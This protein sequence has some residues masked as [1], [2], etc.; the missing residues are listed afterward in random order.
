MMREGAREARYVR[1]A[2]PRLSSV[3]KRESAFEERYCLNE[4]VTDVVIGK[5]LNVSCVSDQSEF[6]RLHM[7]LRSGFLISSVL[8]VHPHQQRP[9]TSNVC[10]LW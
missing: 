7:Q 6:G 9:R 4:D 8:G 5:T 1:V 10:P 2:M 3:R